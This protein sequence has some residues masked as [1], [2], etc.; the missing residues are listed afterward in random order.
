MFSRNDFINQLS[1]IQKNAFYNCA[2]LTSII[3]PRS[4]TIVTNPFEGCTSVKEITLPVESY[5]AFFKYTGG[6]DEVEFWIIYDSNGNEFDR[7]QNGY[8]YVFTDG[9]SYHASPVFL[10][11]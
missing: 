8:N 7:I 9:G 11:N 2:S 1:E 4:V 10:G 5:T 3:L 6:S